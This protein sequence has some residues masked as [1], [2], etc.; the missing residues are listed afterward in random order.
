MPRKSQF[1]LKAS[2]RREN[3]TEAPNFHSE[4]EVSYFKVVSRP[5]KLVIKMASQTFHRAR[6]IT[7]VGGIG[8][9]VLK[10][11]ALGDH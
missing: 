6:N 3:P 4:P 8:I 10:G 1:N 9:D 2:A 11:I 7:Y 5:L